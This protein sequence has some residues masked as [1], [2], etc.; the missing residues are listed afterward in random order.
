MQTI[1]SELLARRKQDVD[2]RTDRTQAPFG[3]PQLS[4]APVTF[5]VSEKTHAVAHSGLALIH[6]IVVQSGLIDAIN[7]VSVL[8]LKLSYWESDHVLNISSS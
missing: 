7:T 6:Q 4:P 8:K 5:E 3:G 1:L 2:F